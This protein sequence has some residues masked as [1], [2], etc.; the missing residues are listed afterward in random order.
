MPDQATDR[1]DTKDIKTEN[2]TGTKD[3]EP[4]TGNPNCQTQIK[5]DP[6]EGFDVKSPIQP[7]EGVELR[8]PLAEG[9]AATTPQEAEDDD[10]IYYHESGDR[11][12]EDLE[13]NLTVLP[14]SPIS[15]TAKVSFEDLQVGDSGSVTPE[16]IEKLRQIIWKKR[17]LLIGKGNALPPAAK[18]VVCDIDV[19]NAKPIALRAR[20]VPARFRE[21]AQT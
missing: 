12:A 7:T 17:H 8:D 20:K 1:T 11:S 6:G 4:K 5:P 10:E 14:E 3:I 21:K 13:G 19:G 18:G 2:R 15:T 9:A 16:Q